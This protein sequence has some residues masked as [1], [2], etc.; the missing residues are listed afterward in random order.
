MRLTSHTEYLKL[1]SVLVKPVA[2]AF[3]SDGFIEKT[4]EGVVLSRQA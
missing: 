2:L 3:K 4:M 1:K